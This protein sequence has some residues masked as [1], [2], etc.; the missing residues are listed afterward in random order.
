M[1]RM[2]WQDFEVNS[3]LQRD[4]LERAMPLVQ[5]ST[6]DNWTDL[7]N[8]ADKTDPGYLTIVPDSIVEGATPE[9]CV[10]LLALRPLLFGTA[11]TVLD[12]LLEEALASAG[13]TPDLA[14]G[15]WSIDR[16]RRHAR[17]GVGQP[18]AIS[19]AAWQALM[20]TYAETSELRHSLVHRAAFT[21][22]TTQAL[23][24]HDR[25]G[26][27][28]RPMTVDEQEAFVR[29]VLRAAE[30]VTA[31]AY[32]ERHEDDLVH[33]LG[34]LTAIHHIPLPR[35]PA[36]LRRSRLTV[37]IPAD[38]ANPGCYVLD[39]PTVKVEWG[40][41]DRWWV[42]LTVQFPD[43]PGQELR[44]RLE[45]APDATVSIDPAAPPGWLSS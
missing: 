5:T 30:L 37:I 22:P 24:G 29:A 7:I 43:R 28:L 3:A 18:S 13:E 36:D 10:E 19:T 9:S 1:L 38:S 14:N 26:G 11:W 17:A 41:P 44:G 25:N 33:Q 27:R 39:V 20:L 34:R 8:M 31:A 35:L 15:N 6:T 12:F 42:D 45:H 32:E 21:D 2:S 40:Q 23:V 4:T 16:K